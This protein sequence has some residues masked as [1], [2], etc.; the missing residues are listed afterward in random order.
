MEG[1]R[2]MAF[3]FAHRSVGL[4]SNRTAGTLRIPAPHEV[5]G[6]FTFSNREVSCWT[7]LRIMRDV[8]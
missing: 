6:H 1:V 5:D 3:K 7:R 2:Q 8:Y 4:L